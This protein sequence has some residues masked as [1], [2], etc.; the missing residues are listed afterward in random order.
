[1]TEPLFL[2]ATALAKNAA[3][4]E[5]VVPKTT[6]IQQSE[7][8]RAEKARLDRLLLNLR[9]NV[10]P[11]RGTLSTQFAPIPPS[12]RSGS[13][14]YSQRV[15]ALQTGQIHTRLP[16]NSFQA[17]WTRS[18][19]QP[20]YEQW[21]NLL[22]QEA[23]IVKGQSQPLGVLLGDSL[24]LWFPSDR[25]P[26]TRHWLNQS[27]SGDTT[28]GILRRLS[29]F[30]NTHPRIIYIMAGV[31]DLKHGAT[32]AAIL[33]NLRQ[34]VQQLRRTHPQA[35]IVLQSILPTRSLPLPTTRIAGLNQRLKAIA[36]QNGA[37]YLDVYS[38]MA[39]A[40]GYL[41]HD[42]TTDGLHLNANGYATWQAVLEKADLWIASN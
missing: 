24:S 32:D 5:T 40:N 26:Q 27:I 35:Q 9:T 16:L 41:R 11:D 4:A 12:P 2:A 28:G 3:T 21:R 13:Q 36:S 31:N 18:G 1:M 30:I 6:Q 17:A 34:I 39:D 14:L 25:L 22:A 29:A 7:S 33:G 19:Q 42:L 23:N 37:Y 20:T 15:A 10:R 8:M 38:R